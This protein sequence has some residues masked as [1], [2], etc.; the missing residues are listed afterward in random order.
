MNTMKIKVPVKYQ[1]REY[2]HTVVIMYLCV[3]LFTALIGISFSFKSSGSTSG[4]E[5]VSAITIFI[6]GLNSFKEIF[7]FFS[8]NGVSRRTLFFSTAAALSILS[9]VFAL[10]DTINCV[11]FTHLTNY[12]SLFLQIYNPRFGL[13]LSRNNPVLTL[14]ILFESFLWLIFLHFFA[15]MVGLFITTL[16]YRMNRGLKIAVSIAVPTLLLNGVSALDF[17]FLDGK[18]S[19]FFERAVKA[20]WGISSGYN[21]YIGMISMFVF[22]AVF[23]AL[24]FL[25]ARKAP[26]RE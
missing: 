13:V 6:I 10:I 9:A 19:A 7:K 21:P 4:L 18:I 5:M 25:L 3:Y 16:Y 20:A 26:V 1:L 24:A 8:A 23:A 2:R 11:I 12:S 15:S 22:A 17:Y 14:Q